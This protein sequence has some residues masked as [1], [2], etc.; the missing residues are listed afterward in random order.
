MSTS[1]EWQER[2]LTP[3]GWVDGSYRVD[4]QGRVEVDPPSDRV[5]TTRYSETWA[6]GAALSHKW[7]DDVWKIADQS[8]VDEL[9]GKFGPAPKTL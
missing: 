8:I 3:N 4:G 6:Y 9:L 2:H 1:D 5:L 7:A